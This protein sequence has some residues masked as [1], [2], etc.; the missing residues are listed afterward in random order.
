MKERNRKTAVPFFF[1]FSVVP[2][3][4]EVPSAAQQRT[5]LFEIGGKKD[6]FLPFGG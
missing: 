5:N 3:A 4:C 6:V 2:A 1:L